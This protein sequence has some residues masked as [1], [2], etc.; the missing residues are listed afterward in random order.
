[1]QST[2]CNMI[3]L[4]PQYVQM[5]LRH[6]NT[7]SVHM[8]AGSGGQKYI[9]DIV[10]NLMGWVEARALQKLRVSAIVDFL[11]EV[12][13]RFRCIIFQLTCNNGTKFKGAVEELMHKYKVPVVHISPYNSQVNGKIE[14]TQQTYIEA[15][16]KVLQGETDQWPLWLGYT[17]WVDQIMV[18]RNTGYSPYY[19]LYGQ[20]PLLPFDITNSTFHILDWPKVTST[21]ELLALR[22]QRLDQQNALIVEACKKN[23]LSQAK[24][25]DAYNWCHADRMGRGEYKK[26]ELVLVYNEVLDNR[27]SGKGALKWCRPY[28]VVARQPSGAYVVQELDALVLKQPIAWKRMKSYV[29]QQGLEPAVLVSRWLSTIDNIKEDLLKDNHNELRV[30]M[31]HVDAIKSDLSW[32]PKLWLLKGEVESEYW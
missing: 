20:H 19:L 25:V 6:F 16:W 9:V 13:C 8:P 28:A 2:Y 31:A 5:I 3:P 24:A 22:I 18:K 21:M 14:R 30:M 11:F 1:M 27:M 12:M 23:F 32:L 15:I 17:L 4:Q 29:P 10:N 26:G 7:N